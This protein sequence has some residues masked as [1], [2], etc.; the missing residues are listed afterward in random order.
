MEQQTATSDVLGV[1]SRSLGQLEPVFQS[2]LANAMRICDAKC[3]V[4][5]SHSNDA[6]RAISC[7]GVDP[8]F[9]EFL[10]EERVWGP[11]TGMGRVARTKQPVHVVDSLA[12]GAYVNRDRGR[13]A[14]VDLGGV[15]TFL[16]VPML[17][18]D[19]LIGAMSIF[20]QELRPYTEKQIKLVTTF[21][22]QA[23]IAIENARLFEEVQART[24]ELQESLEYQTATSE[25]LGVISRSPNQLQP[26]LDAI[27]ETATRLCQADYA[28]FRILREDGAYHVAAMLSHDP[29]GF[30]PHKPILPGHDLVAGRTAI[31]CK[32]IHIPDIRADQTGVYAQQTGIS[33]RTILGVPLVKNG[34]AQGV[35]MLFRD[36]VRPFT[37]R[38]IALVSTFAEQAV[39]A[40]EN[41]RLFEEVQART[42]ELQELLEYQTATSDVLNVISRAPSQLNPVFDAIVE[43][44]A[45]LCR[46]EYSLVYT[47]RGGEY[48]VVATNN[49]EEEFVRYA[50]ANPLRPGRGSLIGRT[51]LEGRTVHMADCLADPEYTVL[52]YQKVGKYRS[53]ARR[54]A[55]PRRS[56]DRRDRPDAQRREAVHGEADRARRDLRRPGGDRDRERAAVRR[57]AGAHARADRSA[58][59]ADRDLR[60]AARSSAGRPSICSPCST[61]SCNR[62][63]ACARRRW[64]RSP[65]EG[66]QY[67]TARAVYGFS[68]EFVEYVEAIR[69]SRTRT[70]AG[71]PCSKAASCT[72]RSA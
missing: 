70:R 42:A 39:I 63:P 23:V 47:L 51:A 21:A 14:S 55:A 60:G 9:E 41:T 7:L 57:G 26:V 69:S 61:R 36:A 72:S 20:R 3:G 52:E 37:N 16:I 45:R 49:A 6:F 58:R 29:D 43:T 53:T 30:S 24:A 17:K 67:S 31:E 13:L 64:R 19:E 48:R 56:D 34:C 35:I 8:A 46:A 22:D 40:I 2:M 50:C 11:D 10:R 28:R 18:D 68:P 12:D 33:A 65:P 27:I 25:V 44:A 32:T 66:R 1:I 54:S 4:M 71:R 5:F 38:Q 15:R 59:A 62:R